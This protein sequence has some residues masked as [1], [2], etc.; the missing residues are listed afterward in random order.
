[1]V[2]T[3]AR[4]QGQPVAPLKDAC[5][6]GS[7]AAPMSRRARS[8]AAG[9]A[10][11]SQTPRLHLVRTT[12]FAAARV[13]Y[14]TQRRTSLMAH[15]GLA[16]R[17]ARL[18]MPALAR[19]MQRA[20]RMRRQWTCPTMR[21]SLIAWRNRTD[22]TTNCL[23]IGSRTC[24]SSSAR[25]VRVA[26]QLRAARLAPAIASERSSRSRRILQAR[27]R[28]GT[29]IWAPCR[30]SLEGQAQCR[31]SPSRLAVRGGRPT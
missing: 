2:T 6:P 18:R 25:M 4:N 23:A 14:A 16:T 13:R 31:A 1:M 17:A 10:A 22:S 5:E 20:A 19:R 21:T 8:C 30:A 12:R 9:A 27:E 7:E 24:L 11:H 3:E 15:R 26:V 28:Q 29:A